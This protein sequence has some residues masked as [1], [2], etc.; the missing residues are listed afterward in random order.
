M[1]KEIEKIITET[2]SCLRNERI[3]VKHVPRENTMVGNN[4]KHVLFGGMAENAVKTL[5][6]P[7]LRNGQL[8]D[9]LTKDEKTFL[10]KYMNLPDNALSVYNKQNNYWSNYSVRLGKSDNY[11]DLSNPDDYIKYAVLRA[12][13]NIVCPNL[14]TLQDKPKITYEFVIISEGEEAKASMTRI[15]ARKKAYQEYG[16]IEDDL[17]TMRVVLEAMTGRPVASTSK[18]EVLAERLDSLIESDAK[19][20]LN[21]VQDPMLKTKVLIREG[22]EAGAIVDRGGQLYLRDGNMPL[23]DNGEPT[24]TV[25]ANF[26]NQPKNQEL[27]FSIEAKIKMY[28]ESK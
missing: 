28:K 19:L 9:V 11:L 5:T 17:S 15:S 8:V 7:Q 25:A 4:P 3:V 1:A 12:N 24:F 13:T 22:I 10:E 27:K 23:C 2:P 14:K 16:K 26:L 18:K 21:I 20:F 6:V